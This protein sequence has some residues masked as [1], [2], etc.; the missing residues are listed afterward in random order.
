MEWTMSKETAVT[1]TYH[2]HE[3]QSPAILTSALQIFLIAELE[4]CG[5]KHNVFYPLLFHGLSP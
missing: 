4:Y 5:L 1:V 2:R 3:F